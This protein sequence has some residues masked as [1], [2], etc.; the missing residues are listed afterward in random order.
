MRASATSLFVLCG[1]TLAIAGPS[2]PAQ[3]KPQPKKAPGSLSGALRDSSAPEGP[4]AFSDAVEFKAAVGEEVLSCELTMTKPIPE[5]MFTTCHL[6]MDLDDSNKTGVNGNDLWVRATV[7][8]RFRGNA[9][10]IG[11]SGETPLKDVR[12]TYS[13]PIRAEDRALSWL[14]QNEELPA[15]TIEGNKMTFGVPM[16]FIKVKNDNYTSVFVVRVSVETSCS[17][18]ALD[19]THLCTDDG[20]AIEID[21]VDKPNEWSGDVRRDAGDELHPSVRRLDIDSFRL[22]HSPAGLCALVRFAEAGF[23]T[24]APASDVRDESQLVF[25]VDPLFPRYQDAALLEIRAGKPTRDGRMRDGLKWKTV[26]TDRTVE[27]LLDRKQG[28]VRFKLFAWSDYRCY[29]DFSDRLRLDWTAK[30]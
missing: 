6:F 25:Y 30:K 21:G 11:Q 18:Q 26:A 17:D 22:D 24:M 29:D 12:T 2:L 14:H 5:G 27:L 4:Y 28:Q 7:G 3:A 19:L 16:R 8:S 1:L 23:A 20:L 10:T 9:Q 15:P 13:V